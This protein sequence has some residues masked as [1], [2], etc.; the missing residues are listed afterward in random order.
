[1]T[2]NTVPA[3]HV[4]AAISYCPAILCCLAS[5]MRKACCTAQTPLCSM[6]VFADGICP[7]SV[8]CECTLVSGWVLISFRHLHQLASK[9]PGWT[10]C[11]VMISQRV[12]LSCC[13]ALAGYHERAKP[14]GLDARSRPGGLSRL[15]GNTCLR[16][17]WL[18]K[19]P[20]L[21]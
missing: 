9:P 17:E 7:V 5:V 12:I 11:T 2:A 18:H 16:A 10:C 20:S 1:M 8:S 6:F 21:Y 13:L 15:A 4:S 3:Q 14:S 19:W